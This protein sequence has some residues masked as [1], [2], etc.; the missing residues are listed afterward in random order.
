MQAF[1]KGRVEESEQ[2]REE[3]VERQA[4]CYICLYIIIF[5]RTSLH[6]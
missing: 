6:V 3:R 4:R 5:T 1:G 2:I